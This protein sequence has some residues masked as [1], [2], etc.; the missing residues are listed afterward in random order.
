MYRGE[1]RNG[2]IVR[3]DSSLPHPVNQDLTH[4]QQ[5]CHLKNINNRIQILLFKLFSIQQ[6]LD[7]CSDKV[8]YEEE[9][10]GEVID[11]DGEDDEDKD[12]VAREEKA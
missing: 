9:G 12:G 2:S 7:D 11:L 4:V 10:G 5:D 6:N 3:V 1:V 8:E